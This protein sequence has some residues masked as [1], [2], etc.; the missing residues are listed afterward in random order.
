HRCGRGVPDR[1]GRR[2][3]AAGRAARRDRAAARVAGGGP[4]ALPSRAAGRGGAGRVGDGR[5]RYVDAMNA[6]TEP[7]GPGDF[8]PT[9][10]ELVFGEAVF[11]EKRFDAL[12]ADPDAAGAASPSGLFMTPVAGALLRDFV[13][14]G[15]GREMVAQAS[16]LLFAAYR[17][18]LHGRHVYRPDE[19]KLRSL[20][21]AEH[22]FADPIVP[23]RAAGYV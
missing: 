7:A 10:W 21:S 1:G 15:G 4:S 14:E 2:R 13:P 3:R 19:A 16:A 17:F 11:D 20:L 6:S 12:R 22:D 5:R 8:R 9:P 23:P 18:W